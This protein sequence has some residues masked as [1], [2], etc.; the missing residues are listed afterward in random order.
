[1]AVICMLSVPA[2]ALAIGV[3]LPTASTGMSTMAE[4]AVLLLATIT[5]ALLL[6]RSSPSAVVD[7]GSEPLSEE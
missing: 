7:R 2:F 4:M 3:F 1:M 6:A 5:T